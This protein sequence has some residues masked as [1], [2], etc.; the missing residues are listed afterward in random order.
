[1]KHQ[2]V[3]QELLEIVEKCR[4]SDGGRLPPER[5]LCAAIKVSRGTL[6]KA[7]D[8]LEAKGLIWRHVGRGTFAGKVLAAR[9]N[10]IEIADTTSPWELMELRLMIEPQIARLAAMRA[11]QTEITHMRHCLEKSEA[12]HDP[13]TYEIWDSTLHRAIAEA[14]HNRLVLSVFET[15]NELRK[16]TAWGRLREQIVSPPGRLE[17]WLLQHRAFVDA[18]ASRDPGRAEVSARIHVEDVFQSMRVGS[19]LPNDDASVPRTS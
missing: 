4:L 17:H 2:Q 1:M 12:A 18:I 3:E 15:V 6:R 7:L 13:D 11:S 9:T 5:E 10:L 19:G 14:A 16:L 8:S